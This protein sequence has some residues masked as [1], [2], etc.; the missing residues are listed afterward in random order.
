MAM[1]ADST[2][3]ALFCFAFDIYINVKSDRDVLHT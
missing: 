3:G 2:L 1:V